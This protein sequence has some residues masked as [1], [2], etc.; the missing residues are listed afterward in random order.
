MIDIVT[1]SSFAKLKRI[2]LEDCYV[3]KWRG[4]WLDEGEMDEVGVDDCDIIDYQGSSLP[5]FCKDSGI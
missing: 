4:K 2:C 5:S 1:S 3:I